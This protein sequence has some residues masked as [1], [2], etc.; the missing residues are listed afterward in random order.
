MFTKRS[1]ANFMPLLQPRTAAGRVEDSMLA[2]LAHFADHAGKGEMKAVA[3]VHNLGDPQVLLKIHTQL[4]ERYTTLAL[5]TAIKEIDS[6]EKDGWREELENEIKELQRT[7]PGRSSSTNIHGGEHSHNQST[8]R[9]WH[10]SGMEIAVLA[11][12]CC[13]F[14]NYALFLRPTRCSAQRRRCK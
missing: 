11:S 13:A 3:R 10:S 9:E 6:S 12:N 4:Q 8:Q 2:Q 5:A 1:V 7:T 14:S